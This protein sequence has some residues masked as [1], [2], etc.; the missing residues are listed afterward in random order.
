M[1]AMRGGRRPLGE[2]LDTLI[3]QAVPG[4]RK[5]VKWNSPF[6]GFEGR[7][8]FA[9][10]HCFNRYVKLAF[11]QGTPPHPLPPGTSKQAEV[12]YLDIHEHDAL[13]EAQLID[14][15]RQASRLSG[16]GKT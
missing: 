14:W 13:D 2:R 5:A 4:V 9:S 7:G 3:E 6:Y 12:R 1:G 10:L 8:W 11:F 15:M 16:W